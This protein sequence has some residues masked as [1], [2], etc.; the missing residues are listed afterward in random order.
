MSPRLMYLPRRLF[1]SLRSPISKRFETTITRQPDATSDSRWLGTIKARIGKCIMFGMSR[2]Q[3][4]DAGKILE[5]LGRDWRELLAG[6]HGYLVD[7]K[8][9][10]LSRHKVVWG[11]WTAW[12]IP[13]LGRRNGELYLPG[14]IL[15]LKHVNNVMYI[16]YAESARVN[17][18]QNYAV[19]IDPQNQEKWRQMCTPEGYGMIMRSIKT[20]YLFPMTWPDHISVYHKLTHKPKSKD[21]FSFKLDVLIVSELHQRVAARCEEDIVTYDYVK[22]KKEGL[23]PWLLDA[24]SKTWDEQNAAMNNALKKIKDIEEKVRKLEVDTWDRADAVEDMGT[25][26]KT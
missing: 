11:R 9:A 24:F 16:R 21:E 13:L 20:M 25:P 18:A 23:Q 5:V 6:R 3:A 7:K 1:I 15:R 22:G 26:K 10:G 19:H 2:E 4:R 17:W 14:R 8:R 12:Y